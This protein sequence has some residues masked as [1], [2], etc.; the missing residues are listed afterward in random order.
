M[1]PRRGVVVGKL[2]CVALVASVQAGC[3]T[4]GV[5]DQGHVSGG[6]EALVRGAVELTA[7]L[8]RFAVVQPAA[9][10]AVVEDQP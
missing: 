8:D 2:A 6:V 1:H 7:E 10:V 4:D 9:V 3:A 5:L